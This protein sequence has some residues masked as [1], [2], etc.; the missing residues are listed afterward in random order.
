MAT[1]L[2]NMM[3]RERKGRNNPPSGINSGSHLHP[4]TRPRGEGHAAA[5][6]TSSQVIKI[7]EIYSNKEATQKQIAKHFGISQPLVSAIIMKKLWKH[8]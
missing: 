6:I 8:I 5:K 2:E 7:R 4:E 1:H 3:D